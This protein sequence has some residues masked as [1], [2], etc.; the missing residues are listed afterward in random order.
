MC[1]NV[2]RRCVESPWGG[3]WEVNGSDIEG[4]VISKTW[5]GRL[6]G[7]GAGLREQGY[8]RGKTQT[9]ELGQKCGARWLCWGTSF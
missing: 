8:I 5:R 7:C 4:S 2:S 6:G 9:T 1:T 3:Q